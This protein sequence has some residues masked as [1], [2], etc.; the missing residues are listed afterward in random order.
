MLSAVEQGVRQRGVSMLGRLVTSA[1]FRCSPIRTRAVP[2]FH[3]VVAELLRLDLC[4]TTSGDRYLLLRTRH[5]HRRRV[6]QLQH[7]R[8]GHSLA[9]GLRGAAAQPDGAT[10]LG[11]SEDCIEEVLL[12]Q[13][14]LLRALPDLACRYVCLAGSATAPYEPA[15]DPAYD[16][17]AGS[18]SDPSAAWLPPAYDDGFG[19]AVRS[20]P[21]PAVLDPLAYLKII[22]QLLDRD[23]KLDDA[24]NAG[25]AASR[26]FGAAAAA[27]TLD[28]DYAVRRPRA[29]HHPPHL[30]HGSVSAGAE[31][32]HV[33]NARVLDFFAAVA[34]GPL[35]ADGRSCA[36]H[37]LA[38]LHAPYARVRDAGDAAARRRTP[39]AAGAADAPG[40]A[41]FRDDANED[42][43]FDA[44]TQA[45][46]A[47]E[48]VAP[49][50][51]P[52]RLRLLSLLGS[53]ALTTTAMDPEHV[54]LRETAF[55]AAHQRHQ[56]QS[57]SVQAREQSLRE[58]PLVDVYARGLGCVRRGARRGR[59]EALYSALLHH[60]PLLQPLPA[61]GCSYD[62][63]PME[64]VIDPASVR[65][66]ADRVL[67]PQVRR[68][69][70]AQG[71]PRRYPVSRLHSA[72][73]SS[74]QLRLL[75]TL[76]SREG[77]RDLVL[78]LAVPKPRA[79]TAA[80][81]QA[82]AAEGVALQA[83]YHYGMPGGQ[84]ALEEHA[85]NTVDP[86]RLALLCLRLPVTLAVKA[87]LLT[88]TSIVAADPERASKVRMGTACA[89]PRWP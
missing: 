39:A 29:H 40:S 2:M 69:E 65:P 81:K 86:L 3:D 10:A 55:N 22:S 45:P 54:A 36:D 32:V 8:L 88:L 57:A 37:V 67:V 89:C 31:D 9:G 14:A 19:V 35:A 59:G 1:A 85:R 4:M 75:A 52:E 73:P 12:L 47:E 87:Q 82:A 58:V 41:S 15:Y 43:T 21:R 30:G 49:S 38:F 33:L 25:A 42:S 13:A 46:E 72:P 80:E 50:A 78:R 18:A 83:A 77:V 76:C 79:W 23:A 56:E 28:D 64:D 6:M 71:R 66:T 63:S 26:R 84:R 48:D 17:R 16:D 53:L 24:G 61:A 62:L 70:G 74:A 60:A 20:L 51:C 7:R 27:E 68:F 44:L 11:V 5:W 34:A